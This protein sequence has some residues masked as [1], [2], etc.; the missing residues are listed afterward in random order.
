VAARASGDLAALRPAQDAVRDIVST[1]EFNAKGQ[2]VRETDGEGYVTEREYDRNGNLTSLV[3]RHNL[4]V[5]T[6]TWAYD[7]MDRLQREVNVEGT[8]TTYQYDRVG[9]LVQRT[10]AEGDVEFRRGGIVIRAERVTYDAAGDLATAS[11]G[12]RVLNRSVIESLRIPSDSLEAVEKREALE[13]MRREATY[14][15]NRHPISLKGKTIILVDD[16]VATGSTMRVAISALR[17]Q[18][19]GRRLGAQPPGRAGEVGPRRGG[20]LRRSAGRSRDRRQA[21]QQRHGPAL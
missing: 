6:Q 18:R 5:Q 16:G 7:R 3:R 13:L 20:I 17:E 10:V 1:V 11:G 15:G 9:N 14:R 21:W 19:A 12:V 2:A 4:E 8:V